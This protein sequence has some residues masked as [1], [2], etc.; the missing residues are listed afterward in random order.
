MTKGSSNPALGANYD[1]TVLSPH[2]RSAVMCFKVTPCEKPRCIRFNLQMWTCVTP[3]Y[4]QRFHL[5]R[6]IREITEKKW[7][8]PKKAPHSC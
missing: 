2:L 1:P 8:D 7:E 4:L 3:F 6:E 5:G